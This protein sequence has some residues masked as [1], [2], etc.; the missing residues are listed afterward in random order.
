MSTGDW[1]VLALILAIIGAAVWFIL[2]SKKQGAK[3]VGCPH[4][5]TCGNGCAGCSG[6]C[7]PQ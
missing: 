4:A 5:K 3:C 2:R 1:I 7:G 6:K